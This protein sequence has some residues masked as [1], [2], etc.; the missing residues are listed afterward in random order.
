MLALGQVSLYDTNSSLIDLPLLYGWNAHASPSSLRFRDVPFATLSSVYY[1]FSNFT[2]PF[3]STLNVS[4]PGN[5][6]MH[7]PNWTASP[8]GKRGPWGDRQGN[9]RALGKA[10]WRSTLPGPPGKVVSREVRL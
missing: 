4:S 10:G 6:T 3:N 8:P 2:S 7:P 5:G 9:V 1:D